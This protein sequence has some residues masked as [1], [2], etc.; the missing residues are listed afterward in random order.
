MI[1]MTEQE[2][3]RV[4]EALVTGGLRECIDNLLTSR[5]ALNRHN[6]QIIQQAYDAGDGV[7]VVLVPG[8]DGWFSG[9]YEGHEVFQAIEHGGTLYSIVHASGGGL[10]SVIVGRGLIEN[11]I[12]LTF[13]GVA[14]AKIYVKGLT[15]K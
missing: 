5:V 8:E 4:Q 1:P 15:A 9:E 10:C 13:H 3:G 2:W 11:E 14:E 6:R 12:G 7:E